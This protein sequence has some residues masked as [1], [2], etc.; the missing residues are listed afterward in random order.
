MQ[1]N[2]LWMNAQIL[3]VC[4]CVAEV[5]VMK[6]IWIFEE[7]QRIKSVEHC[8]TKMKLETDFLFSAVSKGIRVETE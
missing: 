3:C 2:H 5:G 4:V 1:S 8:L 6:K 7:K